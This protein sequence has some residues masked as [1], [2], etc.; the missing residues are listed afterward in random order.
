MSAIKFGPNGCMFRVDGGPC[1][2]K[3]TLQIIQQFKQLYE[4]KLREIERDDGG[5]DN[6][7]AKVCLQRDWIRDL[8]EQNELLV[9]AVEELEREARERVIMLETKLQNTARTGSEVMQKYQDTKFSCNLD[10]AFQKWVYLQN[11][12]RNLL[13]FIRRVRDEGSWSIN[14]LQFYNVSCKD[15]YG[16]LVPCNCSGDSYEEENV[17]DVQENVQKN[18]E[19][20]VQPN[21]KLT[22]E[23]NEN[24]DEQG[25]CCCH[26]SPMSFDNHK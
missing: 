7:E 2:E 9:R 11:D 12:V 16:N 3:E 20:Q 4:T 8:T 6:L 21:V 1:R 26:C 10:K 17:Q 23:I 14:G 15:L 22:F 25:S 19:E 13:E 24:A 18:C 5:G